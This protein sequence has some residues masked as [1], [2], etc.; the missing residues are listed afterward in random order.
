MEI[1]IYGELREQ[2]PDVHLEVAN[3]QQTLAGL[4]QVHG[5]GVSDHLLSN[6][7]HYLLASEGDPEKLVPLTESL[8][9]MPFK[10]FDVLLIIP[11]VE[12]DIWVIAILGVAL[13]AVESAIVASIIVAVI[14]IAVA[15]A[16][17]FLMQMLS[18][19]PEFGSDPSEEAVRKDSSLFHGAPN[20]IEQGGSVPYGAGFAHC[21]GV[22]IS[23][24]IYSE[25]A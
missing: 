16:L 22:L 14:N 11:D 10:Q 18:P 19:T 6:K 12:G 17:G 13:F 1:K 25:D 20:I 7:F 5:Q 2:C 24:G 9:T 8:L 3:I 15:I 4:K 23:A 21:G